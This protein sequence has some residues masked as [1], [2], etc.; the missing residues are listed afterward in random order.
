MNMQLKVKHTEIFFAEFS[1][2]ICILNIY[3]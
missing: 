2:Q 1:N 3:V